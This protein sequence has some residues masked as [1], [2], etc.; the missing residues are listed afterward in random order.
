MSNQTRLVKFNKRSGFS[1]VEV[2]VALAILGVTAA[3]VTTLMVQNQK[4]VVK[5]ETAS[6][7]DASL[8][9]ALELADSVVSDA[10]PSQ[11]RGLCRLMTTGAKMG[12]IGFIEAKL[13]AAQPFAAERPVKFDDWALKFAPASWT[14]VTSGCSD[15]GNYWQRCYR[16]KDGTVGISKTLN[17]AQQPEFR[18]L[19]TPVKL[20][21][22]LN[23]TQGYTPVNLPSA[24]TP[25]LDARDIGFVVTARV[26]YRDG[27]DQTATRVSRERHSLV[28]M[29]AANCRKVVSAN[30]T[31][32]LSASGIGSGNASADQLYSAT[33]KS[34]DTALAGVFRDTVYIRGELLKDSDGNVINSFQVKSPTAT[35]ITSNGPRARTL[36][37]P[38]ST[39]RSG[40]VETS[41][42]CRNRSEPR[43]WASRIESNLAIKFNPN[44]SITKGDG[45]SLRATVEIALEGR[46]DLTTLDR[47][48]LGNTEFMVSPPNSFL[49]SAPVTY[50]AG[51]AIELKGSSPNNVCSNVCSK[52]RNYNSD[53]AANGTAQDTYGLSYTFQLPDYSNSEVRI[54]S[55]ASDRPKLGC[56]CCFT[57][58][59]AAIGT[60]TKGWCYEQPPEP[61]DSRIPECAAGTQST[62][63]TTRLPLT[64]PSVTAGKLVKYEFQGLEASKCLSVQTV[65]V[66]GSLQLRVEPKPCDNSLPILCYA[67]GRFVASPTGSFSQAPQVCY[68]LGQETFQAAELEQMIEN[69]FG[70]R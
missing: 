33:Q 47:K 4:V 56:V 57:K 10:G 53:F 26:L 30:K 39:A 21:S 28:W 2:V 8:Q 69:Q 15:G 65:Q 34:A 36:T 35:W 64:A 17:D 1:I 20:R 7:F 14:P 37:D 29:G 49:G 16:P 40:C 23:A 18:F 54:P 61:L 11:D 66:G 27:T 70:P 62:E 6:V 58:Q 59:C 68:D 63:I 32:I 31:L 45:S 38:A 13:P 51:S 48:P 5:A 67:Q 44:N 9:K 43:S 55:S 22:T 25:A 46:K 3:A 50:A 42:R 60:Q 41:Y 24:A 52:D 12:G 19:I